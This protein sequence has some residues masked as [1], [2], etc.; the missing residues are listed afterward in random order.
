MH[1]KPT[2]KANVVLG[3]SLIW[4]SLII[5][6]SLANIGK[7]K[8]IELEASDKLYHTAC[9]FILGLLWLSFFFIKHGS[10][11]TTK[12][13]IIA[14]SIVLFGIIIEVLQYVLTA[15]RTF[16]LWDAVANVVGVLVAIL[17]FKLM[18]KRIIRK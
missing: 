18:V 17:F 9:Y 4:T 8:L 12:K 15:Y 1:T 5:Y 11:D 6:L 14:I 13:L 10:L 2:W 3:M 16:D 7:I